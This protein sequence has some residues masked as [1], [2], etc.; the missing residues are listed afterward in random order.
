MNEQEL[1]GHLRGLVDR[2]L[3]TED[4]PDEFVFRHA[5][6]RDAVE[7][8]LLGRERRRLHE[9]ALA[10]L[11]D[12]GSADIAALAKHAAGRAGP[13]SSS[14]SR[15]RARRTTS[16]VG[17]PIR[18][19]GS[20]P[21]P[22]PKIRTASRC[23]RP[24]PRR[25][26][27]SASTTKRSVTPGGGVRSRRPKRTSPARPRP[28]TWWPGSSG[29][30]GGSTSTTLPSRTSSVR[31]PA[32]RTGARGRTQRSR[33]RT[34]SRGA[35]KS[36]S[37]VVRA[38]DRRSR[39]MGSQAGARAGLVEKGSALAGWAGRR[40][41]RSRHSVRHR[42]GRGGGRS[43][44]R[45]SRASTTCSGA[46]RCTLARAR[47]SSPRSTPPPRRAGYDAMIRTKHAVLQVEIA[48]SEGDMARPR[49]GSTDGCCGSARSRRARR[50][51]PPSTRSRSGS[52]A[53]GSRTR[54]HSRRAVEF[55]TSDEL[56]DARGG[57]P[58]RRAARQIARESRRCCVACTMSPRQHLR[59]ER[60]VDRPADRVGPSRRRRRRARARA[61]RPMLELARDQPWVGVGEAMLLAAEGDHRGALDQF[62]SVLAHDEPGLPV[63]LHA[64][65][66]LAS[67]R[68][69][70]ALGERT[71][72]VALA[73][74]ARGAARA[75]AGLP[76]RR[77]RRLP[78]RA[79]R[80]GPPTQEGGE[81]TAREREVAGL[82]ARG[83]T[84]AAI[85]E[86]LYISPRTAAVH[87]SNILA[88][89]GLANRSELTAWAVRSGSAGR[90]GD[91]IA[92]ASSS[93]GLLVLPRKGGGPAE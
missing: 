1:I 27:S 37:S 90:N 8:Q 92:R 48:I 5:L 2:G 64:S 72:A 89:L 76:P 88:K 25:R 29:T 21:T 11:R 56:W 18:R 26:G 73:T 87:V 13:T 23:S 43:R 40:P 71:D 33:R 68:C 59:T 28:P 42:R 49:P 12:S 17:R 52:R 78:R 66:L 24:R 84:N 38:R 16:S 70:L 20:R 51:G 22:S 4:R 35:A 50:N 53:D 82:V 75:V 93:C 15:T 36:L 30:S 77:G 61:V 10:A 44:R 63:S 47:R 54:R 83:L 74:E 19:C 62:D 6:V 55:M 57:H 41:R 46:C 65:L 7:D 79:T 32:S 34:C 39:S 80:P 81:L 67:A 45:R 9:A 58:A 85:A 31:R 3:I 60:R 14:T 69:H 86:Q 91:G